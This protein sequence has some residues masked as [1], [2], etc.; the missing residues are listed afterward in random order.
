MAIIYFFE[1]KK[2]V[3]FAFENSNFKCDRTREKEWATSQL[4]WHI[5]L[6][7][8]ISLIESTATSSPSFEHGSLR[9]AIVEKKKKKK[10]KTKIGIRIRQ[11]RIFNRWFQI[12]YSMKIFRLLFVVYAACNVQRIKNKLKRN[13]RERTALSIFFFF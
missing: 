2:N 9:P 10:E 6:K 11:I 13:K 8:F 5:H 12:L 1:L 3:N 4:T 7:H